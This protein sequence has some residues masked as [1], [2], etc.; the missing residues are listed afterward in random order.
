MITLDL[1]LNLLVLSQAFEDL[2]FHLMEEEAQ[3]ESEKEELLR[4]I[5]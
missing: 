4:D 5:R 2:E 1:K 3:K